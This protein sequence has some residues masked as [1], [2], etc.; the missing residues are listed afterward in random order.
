VLYGLG[1]GAVN[2]ARTYWSHIYHRQPALKRPD[3]NILLV[4]IWSSIA[5]DVSRNFSEWAASDDGLNLR[6]RLLKDVQKSQTTEQLALTLA[7]WLCLQRLLPCSS[8]IT[9]PIKGCFLADLGALLTGERLSNECTVLE[10]MIFSFSQALDTFGG[11]YQD[12]RQLINAVLDTDTLPL[13][14]PDRISVQYWIYRTK[15]RLA[16]KAARAWTQWFCMLQ[17]S[18][19]FLAV[20]SAVVLSARHDLICQVQFFLSLAL[21]YN[22]W[23]VVSLVVLYARYDQISELY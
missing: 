21:R 5:S 2:E 3:N 23:T 4:L 17:S 12:T 1:T 13:E 9:Q 11:E 19:S 10:R 6:R 16:H 14:H 20:V 22:F 18:K 15:K 7:A 8:D